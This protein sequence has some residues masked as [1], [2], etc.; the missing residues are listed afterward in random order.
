MTP[1]SSSRPIETSAMKPNSTSPML[2]GMV[3]V[4]TE[5]KAMTQALNPLA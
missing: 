1:P 2:G 3:A 5:P 4:I